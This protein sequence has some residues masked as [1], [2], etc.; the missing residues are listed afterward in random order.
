MKQESVPIDTLHPDPANV[1]LHSER[2]LEAIKA[3]LA[4]FGQQKPIV[5][6]KNNVVIAGNGTMQAATEL[7]WTNIQIVR[8]ELEGSDATA[9]A[10]ADNRTAELAEWD[11]EKLA[12]ALASIEDPD[13]LEV[14]GFTDEELRLLEPPASEARD[15]TERDISR[16]LCPACGA[17]TSTQ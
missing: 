14:T 15:E 7:G 3:S 1:R 10:I 8:S 2:N 9:F 5:V 11:E 4:R 12:S 17:P 16:N 6:G 13:E